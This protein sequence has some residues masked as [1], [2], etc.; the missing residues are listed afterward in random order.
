M[1][2]I[3]FTVTLVIIMIMNWTAYSQITGLDRDQKIQIVST[4]QSYDAVLIEIDL[5]D[6]LL[7]QCKKL[8]LV[9]EQRI[10]LL[11]EINENHKL[12]DETFNNEN[13]YYKNKLK[14]EKTKTVIAAALAGVLAVILIVN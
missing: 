10:K 3:K 8:N 12:K 9:Y 6:Q 1:K 2:Q 7:T 4:L 14:K 5:T 13:D 11:E